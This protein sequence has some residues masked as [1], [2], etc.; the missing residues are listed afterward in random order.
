MS[1]CQAG[2]ERFLR[3]I[4]IASKRPTETYRVKLESCRDNIEL[5]SPGL[6][7]SPETKSLNIHWLSAPGQI[8]KSE[9]RTLTIGTDGKVTPGQAS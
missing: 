7:W 5:A 1:Y 6:K 9:D 8:G 2:E 4:E 3:V